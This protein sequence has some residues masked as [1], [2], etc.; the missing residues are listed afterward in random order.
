MNVGFNH[1]SLINPQSG[2]V[3]PD[4]KRRP[5][6][7]DRLT[8]SCGNTKCGPKKQKLRSKIGLT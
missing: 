5:P 6:L 3:N 7:N 1:R 2:G 8:S 4:K